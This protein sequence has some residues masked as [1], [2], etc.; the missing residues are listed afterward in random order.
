MGE[1]RG[2]DDRKGSMRELQ[3]EARAEFERAQRSDTGGQEHASRADREGI[4]AERRP[5]EAATRDVDRATAEQSDAERLRMP[6]GDA[7][8]GGGG[9]VTRGPTPGGAG[10]PGDE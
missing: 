8:T 2:I 3:R 4:P 1:R 10:E 9:N 7:I 5:I 6:R